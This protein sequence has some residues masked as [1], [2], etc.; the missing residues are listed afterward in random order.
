MRRLRASIGLRHSCAEGAEFSCCV[1]HVIPTESVIRIELERQTY[2]DS[3]RVHEPAT[4]CP[5]R[6]SGL[7][8][9]LEGAPVLPDSKL[10]W[11]RA[12]EELLD[13]SRDGLKHPCRGSLRSETKT[14]GRAAQSNRRAGEIERPDE[15]R[16]NVGR[17]NRE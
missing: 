10:L 6:I 4:D 5:E 9:L 2:A 14:N 13:G 15:S 8:A 12:L 1:H 16:G 7:K 3:N 11:H 17:Q